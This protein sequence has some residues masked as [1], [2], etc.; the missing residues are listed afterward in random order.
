[1]KLTSDERYKL[2]TIFEGNRGNATIF[3]MKIK[4]F[5]FEQICDQLEYFIINRNNFRI[6]VLII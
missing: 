1:M 5:N 4:R 3:F 6:F 2:K